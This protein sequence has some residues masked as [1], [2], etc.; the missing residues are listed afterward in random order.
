VCAVD[1]LGPGHRRIVEIARVSIGIFN[2]HGRFYALR[3]RCPH[4]GGALCEGPIT[5]TILHTDDRQ[6]VYGHD[7]C[8]VRCAWHG[9]EFDIATGRALADPSCAARCYPVSV[10]AGNIY[11]HL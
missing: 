6:F 7:G 11:V 8:F 10:S 3:N 2:V 1:A 5:G 9:W 4:K